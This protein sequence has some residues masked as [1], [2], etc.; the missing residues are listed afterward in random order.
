MI[1]LRNG[2]LVDGSGA[3]PVAGATVV[4]DGNRIAAVSTRSESD[5]PA[6]ATVIDAA[7][8]TLLPGLIDCHDH[9]ANHKYDLA[10]RWRLDEPQSTRH[11]RTAAVLK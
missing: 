2:R 4:I 8:M 9:M 6:G 5:F 1:V 7:G 11:L 10:H 3:A